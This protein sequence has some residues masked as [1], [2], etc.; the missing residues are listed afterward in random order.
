MCDKSTPTILRPIK[1][2]K[3]EAHSKRIPHSEVVKY[4]GGRDPLLEFSV[5]IQT[6]DNSANYLL[7]KIEQV[8]G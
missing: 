7:Q 2:D 6:L 4:C 1:A 5:S 3:I 8:A